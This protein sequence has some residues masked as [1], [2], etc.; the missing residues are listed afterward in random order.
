MRERLRAAVVSCG[1]N[2]R[3][4]VVADFSWFSDLKGNTALPVDRP[5]P[6]TNSAPKADCTEMSYS[7]DPVGH[8]Y[9]CR[10]HEDSEAEWSNIL[11]ERRAR[12]E[13]NPDVW[14][15][16]IDGDAFEVAPTGAP[17]GDPSAEPAVP[18][19]DDVTADDLD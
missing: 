6:D 5:T 15:P 13:L 16:V 19:P 1:V 8:K 4:L 18:A 11:A 17:I 14:P 12:G 7:E 2:K 10:P 3:T 9:C